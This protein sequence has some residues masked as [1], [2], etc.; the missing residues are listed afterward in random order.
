MIFYGQAKIADLA[1]STAVQED[2]VRLDVEVQD[3]LSVQELEALQSQSS[4]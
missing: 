2:V 1:A 4:L 3:A